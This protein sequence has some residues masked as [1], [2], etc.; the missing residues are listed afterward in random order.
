MNDCQNQ[1]DADAMRTTSQINRPDAPKKVPKSANYFEYRNIPHEKEFGYEPLAD[2]PDVEI[3]IVNCPV[4]KTIETVQVSAPMPENSNFFDGVNPSIR[5]A[6]GENGSL[7]FSRVPTERVVR[8]SYRVITPEVQEPTIIVYHNSPPDSFF[9]EARPVTVITSVQAPTRLSY[10]TSHIE[11]ASEDPN[12]DIHKRFQVINALNRIESNIKALAIKQRR[13]DVMGSALLRNSRVFVDESSV[14]LSQLSQRQLELNGLED[15]INRL[16]RVNLD[17]KFSL[18][19]RVNQLRSQINGFVNS[20][21]LIEPTVELRTSNALLNE[22]VV[23]MSSSKRIR[24]NEE[25]GQKRPGSIT[26]VISS[27]PQ[28]ITYSNPPVNTEYIPI[29]LNGTVNLNHIP[30]RTIITT[31]Q[32]LPSSNVV[33]A[34]VRQSYDR[35]IADA[36][37]KVT[38]YSYNPTTY[39]S[40]VTTTQRVKTTVEQPDHVI[41]RETLMTLPM[42]DIRESLNENSVKPSLYPNSVLP[43]EV[44]D[45]KRRITVGVTNCN[46][47]RNISRGEIAILQAPSSIR[48]IER[49][50]VGSAKRVHVLNNSLR[51]SQNHESLQSSSYKQVDLVL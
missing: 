24:V 15:D 25:H 3:A 9:Q 4:F 42:S 11:I 27:E 37:P 5:D 38:R 12:A 30:T 19:N 26:R 22:S 8:T 45:S 36:Q 6:F 34:D 21:S 41:T 14:I 28:V 2:E 39:V 31:Q 50:S 44:V 32:L 16:A 7:H 49:Q 35:L 48:S 51:S 17:E 18:L 20:K 1:V 10:T 40:N 29:T 47:D 33:Y 43:I 46:S 23:S 13:I